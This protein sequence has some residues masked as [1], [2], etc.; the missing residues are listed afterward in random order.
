MTIRE[1]LENKLCRNCETRVYGC[2]YCDTKLNK[3][4]PLE[5]QIKELVKERLPKYKSNNIDKGCECIS[6]KESIIYNQAI[7]DAIKSIEEL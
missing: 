2:E 1:I 6:C 7:K 3:I 4:I 5:Q